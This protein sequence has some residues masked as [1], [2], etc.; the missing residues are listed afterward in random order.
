MQ[1]EQPSGIKKIYRGEG[2]RQGHLFSQNK[3]ILLIK[4]SEKIYNGNIKSQFILRRR[5]FLATKCPVVILDKMYAYLIVVVR[6]RSGEE[7]RSGP[8][9]STYVCTAYSYIL[10]LYSASWL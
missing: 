2:S 5:K 10:V 6:K 8:G 3:V 7:A 9:H 4:N 1:G